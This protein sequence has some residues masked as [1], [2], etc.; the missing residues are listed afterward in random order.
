MANI[1]F[2]D[3]TANATIVQADHFLVGFDDDDRNGGANPKNNKWTFSQVAAGLPTFYAGDGSI[4]ED[5]V[6]T[7][8]HD[9]T[10]KASYTTTF[11]SNKSTNT[12]TRNTALGNRIIL[13]ETV[14][15][16][17]TGYSTSRGAGFNLNH[18]TSGDDVSGYI[19][20]QSI[21]S[22]TSD[23]YGRS[24]MGFRTNT[25]FVFAQTASWAGDALIVRDS[26]ASNVSKSLRYASGSDGGR[27][28]LCAPNA[29]TSQI[30]LATD[31]SNTF[32]RYISGDNNGALTLGRKLTSGSEEAY[33]TCSGVGGYTGNIAV[34]INQSTP[35]ETLE[36]G[37][38][39]KI[40]GQGYT[41]QH[42]QT[43]LAISWNNSNVV[44]ATLTTGTIIFN[45]TDAK[46][47]A[48][49]ILYL[50]QPAS[51]GPT[52]INWNNLVLWPGGTPP[53]LSTAAGATDVI[54]LIY[55]GT[56]T[57]YFGTSVLN[58]S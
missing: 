8:G 33:I 58:F 23:Y 41:E 18:N 44:Y 40:T 32:Y 49:Y 55:N 47:G 2:S 24:Q 13:T 3:F 11:D 31:V 54:T 14:T 1:K 28:R 26:L 6:V 29:K 10:T 5:R 50:R 21:N 38:N 30:L 46:S 36:V 16:A 35:T 45:P 48:T 9:S 51:G 17:P 19:N 25:G 56:S 27:L 4:N 42:D 15:S 37:G 34:G 22:G 7:V 39:C 53:T 52:L 12:T 57:K 20:V 43:D